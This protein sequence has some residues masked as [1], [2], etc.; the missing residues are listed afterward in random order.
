YE[1]QVPGTDARVTALN[2]T[3]LLLTTPQILLN[4]EVDDY[5]VVEDRA[6]GCALERFGY[7]R[8]ARGSHSSGRRAG[9]GVTLVGGEMSEIMERVLRERFG[10]SPLDYQLMEEE[11]EQGF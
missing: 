8:H 3:S 10:A 9:W 11:D 1:R 5:G 2:I 4:A 7:H 6:C